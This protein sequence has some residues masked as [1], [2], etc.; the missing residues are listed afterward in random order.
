M[1]VDFTNL[2]IFYKWNHGIYHSY[3]CFL[4]FTMKHWDFI[5]VVQCTI[6]FHFHSPMIFSPN[7]YYWSIHLLSDGCILSTVK[8]FW[9]TLSWTF[10]NILFINISFHLLWLNHWTGLN[11]L[12]WRTPVLFLKWLY[13][14]IFLLAVS[15]S[16]NSQPLS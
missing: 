16:F 5:F 14:C 12:L 11:V 7:I 1:C 2:S 4:S 6:F 9:V 8:L 15:E 13:Y 10:V 3:N